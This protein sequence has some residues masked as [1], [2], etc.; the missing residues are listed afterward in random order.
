MANKKMMKVYNDTHK[1]ALEIKEI[2]EK[3][4]DRSV[5]LADVSEIAIDKLHRQVVK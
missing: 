1:K 3:E 4:T 2:K 5:T